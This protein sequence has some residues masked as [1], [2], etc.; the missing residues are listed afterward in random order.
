MWGFGGF[1][2]CIAHGHLTSGPAAWKNVLQSDKYI[3]KIAV[4]A[5]CPA[6]ILFFSV[7]RLKV[8]SNF[9][10]QGSQAEP[11]FDTTVSSKWRR[12]VRTEVIQWKSRFKAFL[13]QPGASIQ[14]LRFL[15]PVHDVLWQCSSFLCYLKARFH[16]SH[17][18]GRQVWHILYRLSDNSNWT[19]AISHGFN[20]SCLFPCCK[21][22]V[23]VTIT[24]GGLLQL[25]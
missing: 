3:W 22:L 24:A 4:M 14:L 5:P 6:L 18:L 10:S 12:E 17:K 21:L 25:S 7:L 11:L 8:N 15:A 23:A 19:R 16:Q 2:G 13:C 1:G 20:S 9:W